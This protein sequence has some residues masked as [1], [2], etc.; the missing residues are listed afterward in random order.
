[1]LKE[2]WPMAQPMLIMVQVLMAQKVTITKLIFFRFYFVIYYRGLD[3][4]NTR[5]LD[6]ANYFLSIWKKI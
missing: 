1:M 5:S 2:Q 6:V 3:K 4:K